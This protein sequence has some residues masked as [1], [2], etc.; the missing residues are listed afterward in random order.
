MPRLLTVAREVK[1]PLDIYLQRHSPL[2]PELWL[3][4]YSRLSR[5]SS[6]ASVYLPGLFYAVFLRGVSCSSALRVIYA[7]FS[8]KSHLSKFNLLGPFYDLSRHTR[9]DAGSTML[10]AYRCL[11]TR[12]YIWGYWLVRFKFLVPSSYLRVWPSRVRPSP[13]QLVQV[14]VIG[15]GQSPFRRAS[16]CSKLGCG[17]RGIGDWSF[18]AIST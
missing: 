16:S 7:F 3:R 13:I 4:S 10:S 8:R 5:T 17:A 9:W 18:S 12:L 15:P 2:L 14:R 6:F 1:T 11:Y